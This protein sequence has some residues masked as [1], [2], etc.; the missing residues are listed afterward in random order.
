MLYVLLALTTCAIIGVD[1]WTKYLTI[2][3]IPPGADVPFWDGVFHFTHIYN[4]GAA[5]SIL[6]G[7]MWF[8]YLI[9]GL[10]LG[11]VALALWKKWIRH[12]LGLFALAMVAGGA[13][14]NLIDR[15]RFHAVVDMIELDFMN[16]A[17][18]NVADCFIVVGAIILCVWAIFFEQKPK[19]NHDDC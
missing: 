16:F 10:F 13:I 3:H 17:I 2:T 15:V 5:F 1:Q 18:F 19:E 11:A 12:P 7:K 4:E 14:G 9:S 6:E 8:F